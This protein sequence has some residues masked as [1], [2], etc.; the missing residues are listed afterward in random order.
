ML[1]HHSVHVNNAGLSLD[2]DQCSNVICIALTRLKFQ[3]SVA[4][5]RI[6]TYMISQRGRRP[7][8]NNNIYL[9]NSRRGTIDEHDQIKKAQQINTPDG[10]LL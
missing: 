3:A 1:I 9:K 7:T 6:S 5:R 8:A 10:L 4:K 2:E